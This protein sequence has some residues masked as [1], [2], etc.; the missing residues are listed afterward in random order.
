MKESADVEEGEG[1]EADGE[2]AC[3]RGRVF[4]AGKDEGAARDGD[5][6][7]CGAGCGVREAEEAGEVRVAGGHAREVQ[8]RS[9][10]RVGAQHGCTGATTDGTRA[11]TRGLKSLGHA[12]QTDAPRERERVERDA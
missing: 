3:A 5:G 2:T 6:C 4:A 11:R 12:E 7:G 1:A 10:G 8:A 9:A